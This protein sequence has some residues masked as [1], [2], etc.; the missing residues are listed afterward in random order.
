MMSLNFCLDAVELVCSN[1]Y[2]NFFL[3]SKFVHEFLNFRV[4]IF[5]FVFTNSYV[6]F[7][8]EILNFCLNLENFHTSSR[9][10]VKVMLQMACTVC[11]YDFDV[12]SRKD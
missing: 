7:V 5:S 2:T 6:N 4:R 12:K 9:E 3:Y 8:H 1:L 10:F 11:N